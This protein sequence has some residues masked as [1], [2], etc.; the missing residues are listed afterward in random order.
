MSLLAFCLCNLLEVGPGG[1]VRNVE[2]F[3]DNLYSI[4][5]LHYAKLC[6]SNQY[7]Y[8]NT[9]PEVLCDIHKS[10]TRMS[11]PENV[12]I[13]SNILRSDDV[14]RNRNFKHTESYSI[15]TD[16]KYRV[17]CTTF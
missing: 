17:K 6:N 1:N 3:C 8:Q 12:M 7:N 15:V 16:I 9:M 11:G 5:R 4:I 2:A 14:S 13:N 10:L